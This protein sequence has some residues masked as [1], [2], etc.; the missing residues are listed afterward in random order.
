M[1]NETYGPVI[2]LLKD[3]FHIDDRDD[4]G[5]IRERVA[6]KLLM[7]D[8]KLEPLLPVL[9]FVLGTPIEDGQWQR[10]DPPQRR[11]RILDACKQLLIR[12]AQVQPLLV[13]FEDLHWIDNET[14]ALL[15][16]LVES[17]PSARIL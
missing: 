3:Y 17:L 15:D 2:H 12:E 8:R 4:V 13:V 7:L 5:R 10:L 11:L 6:G 16:N 14:Q 1:A 9:L